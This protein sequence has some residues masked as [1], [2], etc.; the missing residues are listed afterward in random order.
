MKRIAKITIK[1]IADDCPDLSYLGDY[2]NSAHEGAID[3]QANGDCGRGEYRFFNPA[4]PEYAEQEYQR[5]EAYHRGSWCC[6]GIRAEAVI[7]TSDGVCNSISSGGLWGIESDSDDRYLEEIAREELAALRG[8]LAELGFSADE[9]DS[10]CSD[11]E[12]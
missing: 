11:I 6:I 5:M 3:R 7:Q 12:H 1:Q 9:I 10:A 8:T 4:N 2:S